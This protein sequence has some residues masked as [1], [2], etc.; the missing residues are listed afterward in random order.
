MNIENMQEEMRHRQFE[1]YA[2][3]FFERWQ[4]K[5]QIEAQQFSAELFSLVRKIYVDANGPA[6]DMI[7]KI[8]QCLPLKG[9]F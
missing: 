7:A 3:R 2:Q 4:P 6:N 1:I 9:G 5:D 8:M